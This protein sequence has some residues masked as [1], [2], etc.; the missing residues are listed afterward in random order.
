[1][2]IPTVIITG[3]E[4]LNMKLN[5]MRSQDAK[6]AI[7]QAS[8]KALRPVKAAVKRE[9]PKQSGKLRR[10]FR[11]RT[12]KRS[13]LRVGARLTTSAADSLFQGKQ[14]YGA[15]Q[16]FG[17]KAGRR[18]TNA[19]LGASR[20][21]RRTTSQQQLAKNLNA[22]R[23]EVPAKNFI[24]RGAEGAKDAAIGIYR[25]ELAKAF[26]TLVGTGTD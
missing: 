3:D 2:P 24:K 11:I 26:E 25:S 18:V 8:R 22:S 4:T 13:R 21:K 14:Y 20:R 6:K 19:D 10:S 5:L 17:W 1:M 23:R 9:T 7:R 15:F 16:E 12:M